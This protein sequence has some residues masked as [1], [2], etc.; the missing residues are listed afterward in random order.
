M[1]FAAIF[2]TA[3]ALLAALIIPNLSSGSGLHADNNSTSGTS[4]VEANVASDSKLHN[5]SGNYTLF[6]MPDASFEQERMGSF[7]LWDQ[8][9]TGRYIKRGQQV[10]VTVENLA[11]DLYLAVTV[12]FR[13]MWEPSE[14]QQE[15]RLDNGETEFVATQDG[16]I[17]LKLTSSP[18]S[19]RSGTAVKVSVIGAHPLPLYVEGQTTT[20]EW[21]RQLEAYRNAPFVQLLST[22]SLITLPVEDYR[23][24]PVASPSR[25]LAAIDQII[26]M[27]DELAGLDGDTPIHMPSPLR[28]HFLVDFRAPENPPFYMYATDEFIGLL[29]ENFTGLTNP[30]EL[31]TEW[32]VWHE[33]GHTYQQRSWTWEAMEEVSVNLF[34]LY[35]QENLGQPSR[36]SIPDEFG[37]TPRQQ[38]AKYIRQGGGNFMLPHSSDQ[39]AFTRLVMLEE[40]KNTYGWGLFKKMFRYFREHPQQDVDGRQAAD[41]FIIV[42]SQLS[43]DDL[44]P[45]FKKWGLQT[46][47][48][49]QKPPA[50]PSLR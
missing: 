48:C 22:R 38:A 34:S 10:T 2:L 43:G 47:G 12:G 6:P 7:R 39:E 50:L 3:T 31:M 23:R 8:Q 9:P 25:S 14:D 17:Y 1:K 45:F 26:G 46:S 29:S 5:V 44:S 33:I 21:E 27:S 19:F 35:I 11:N 41:S 15:I 32:G 20:R 30:E 49:L 42:M 40:L 16:P 37:E 28:H 13:P 4:V 24:H 36:L 18:E